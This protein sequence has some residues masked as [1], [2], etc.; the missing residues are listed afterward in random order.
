MTVLEQDLK[1]IDPGYYGQQIKTDLMPSCG[2]GRE[3][4]RPDDIAG[5]LFQGQPMP[6][7]EICPK[8][9]QNKMQKNN[10]EKMLG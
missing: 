6:H 10:L 3:A 4:G 9:P 2:N 7:R 5:L 1:K 8:T